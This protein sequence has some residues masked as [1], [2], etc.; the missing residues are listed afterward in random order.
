MSDKA[1]ATPPEEMGRVTPLIK[2]YWTQKLVGGLGLIL[3][4]WT[5]WIAY[6]QDGLVW[7][8]I[9]FLLYIYAEFYWAWK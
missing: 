8:G 3:H 9:H 7:A 1:A 4:F 6:K 5:T 2:L